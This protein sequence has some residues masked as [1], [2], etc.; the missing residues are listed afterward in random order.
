MAKRFEGGK[1]Y[2]GRV[3][4]TDEESVV[5]LREGA[6]AIGVGV[7][8]SAAGTAGGGC[9]VGV[10]LLETRGSWLAVRV[11]RRSVGGRGSAGGVA[12]GADG[13]GVVTDESRAEVKGSDSPMTLAV[14]SSVES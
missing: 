6:G 13:V 10:A 3:V 7:V 4:S 12:S 8:E 2:T 11:E 9:D 14:E 1:V 5:E